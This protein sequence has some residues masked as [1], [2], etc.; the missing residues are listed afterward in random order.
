MRSYPLCDP[1]PQRFGLGLDVTEDEAGDWLG[2]LAPL[3]A[4]R[5]RAVSHGVG[6]RPDPRQELCAV[7]LEVLDLVAAPDAPRN[8]VTSAVSG[9]EDRP[10]SLVPI[11][12]P[13]GEDRVDLVHQQG[14]E[15]A[16]N[17]PVQHRLRWG[18][19]LP[20][21]SY[22]YVDRLDQPGLPA[23]FLRAGDCEVRR[24]LEDL[25]TV[26]VD[27]PQRD[28]PVLRFAEDDIP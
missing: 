25:D 16:G 5:H 3:H 12:R 15:V 11:R 4:D 8:L 1:L 18:D 26:G 24:L 22:Q 9:I 27:N 19:G 13:R 14:R 21:S 28:D 10:V 20:R 7:S 23:S 17:L 2:L 6:Q